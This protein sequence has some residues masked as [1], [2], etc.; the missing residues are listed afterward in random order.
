MNYSRNYDSFGFLPVKGII[1]KSYGQCKL[2]QNPQTNALACEL[3]TSFY[4]EKDLKDAERQA[5]IL[6]GIKSNNII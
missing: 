1:D 3:I 5:G 4:F 2:L 6:I